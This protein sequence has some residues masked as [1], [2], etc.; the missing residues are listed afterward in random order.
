M[1][2]AAGDGGAEFGHGGGAEKSVE[3]ANNPHAEIE[4]GVRKPF[5]D[6]AGRTHNSGG[7]RV[8]NGCGDAEPHAQDL[9]QPAAAH[10]LSRH[11]DGR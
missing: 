11:C 8:A 4:P 5:G 1:A 6:V 10:L 7:D 3:A 2:A 9:K